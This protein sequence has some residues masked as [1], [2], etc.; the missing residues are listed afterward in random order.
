MSDH[1]QPSQYMQ[2]RTMYIFDKEFKLIE[3]GDGF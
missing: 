3:D 2:F 1:I